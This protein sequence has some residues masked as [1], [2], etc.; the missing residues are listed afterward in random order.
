MYQLTVKELMS[1]ELITLERDETLDL[2]TE[3]MRLARI[4]HLPVIDE[5][6]HLCGLVTHRD[7]L[8]AQVS[9]LAGLTR[10]ELEDLD[11]SISVSTI[12]TEDVMTIGPDATALDAAKIM[13]EHRIGCLP[14]TEGEAL[15]G[16]ITEA[17][18]LELDIRALEKKPA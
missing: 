18:F 17:D 2:A 1:T 8:G 16:I 10:D 13:R 7:L 12:M 9:A 5:S 14:V 11:S 4:R 3:I 6:G 15:V